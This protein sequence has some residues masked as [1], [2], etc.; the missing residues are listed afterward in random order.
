M[1]LQEAGFQVREHLH[2][3]IAGEEII[4]V[5]QAED[6]GL[7]VVG[8]HGRGN[9]ASAVLGSVSDFVIRNSTRPVLV[10]RRGI[11]GGKK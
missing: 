4:R 3:G 9:L 1:E 10:V 11:P 2:T 8:S 6:V 7:I 5:A